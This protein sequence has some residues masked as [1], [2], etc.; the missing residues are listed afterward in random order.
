MP[1]PELRVFV[2]ID[3]PS[4]EVLSNLSRARDLLVETGADLKPVATENLHLTIRFIGEV[5]IKIVN[6]ICRG[7]SNLVFKPFKIRVSGIGVFPSI[8]RPR[9]IWAGVSE[10]VRELVQI[11]DEVNAVLA[12]LGMPP[13]REKFVPHVTLARVRSSRNL[14][15]LVKVINSIISMEFGE[16]V[17]DRVTL[18]KSTLTPSGP[19]YNDVC[20]VKAKEQ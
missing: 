18:K 6:E 2:A 7:L 10:G 4:S 12:K 13:E 1:S 16:F 19:I 3:I 11:H 17:V 14:S 9:V 20:S 5:P 15:R 8:A